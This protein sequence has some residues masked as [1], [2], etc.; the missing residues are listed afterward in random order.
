VGVGSA[1]THVVIVGSILHVPVHGGE[2]ER[3]G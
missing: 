3:A 1:G 2:V